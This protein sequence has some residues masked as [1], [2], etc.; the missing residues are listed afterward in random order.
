MV[1]VTKTISEVQ[2]KLDLQNVL[3]AS[4]IMTNLKSASRVR[5]NRFRINIDD[6]M[7]DSQKRKVELFHKLSCQTNMVGLEMLDG[8]F[9]AVLRV[10]SCEEAHISTT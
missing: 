6:D 3:F 10:Q 5:R 2:H 4:D 8:L 1:K 7:D 9:E